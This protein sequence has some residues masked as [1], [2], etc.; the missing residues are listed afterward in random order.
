RKAVRHNAE[1]ACDARKQKHGSD[2]E[3]DRVGNSRQR[4]A[5]RHEVL[6]LSCGCGALLSAMNPRDSIC[7]SSVPHIDPCTHRTLASPPFVAARALCKTIA[8]NGPMPPVFISREAGAP[9]QSV[10]PSSP[11]QHFPETSLTAQKTA[12]R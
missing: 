5:L 4:A 1:Q 3:L 2:R 8:M 7:V 11:L 10:A 12:F 6:G 9:Q